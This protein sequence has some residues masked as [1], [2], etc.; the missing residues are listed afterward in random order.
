MVIELRA[1]FDEQA[2]IELANQLQAA[3]AQVVYGVVR[4]KTH[5]KMSMVIRREGRVLRRYVHLGT[6][7]YHARTARAYTDYGLFTCDKAIGEDVH[8]VFQQL[9]AMGRP[10]RLKK[11]LQSPFTLHRD[12][13]RSD[14]ARGGPGVEG[15]ACAR[16]GED[17]RADRSAG[18]PGAV[19]RVA[20]RR[21]D[22]PDRA[23]HVCAAAGRAGRFGQHPRALDRRSL[24][25]ARARVLLR[26]RRRPEGVSVERRLD[27][28]QLLQ[29]RRNRVSDR[30]QAAWRGA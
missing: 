25:R 27:G 24:P 9:T 16:H 14:R 29:P 11:L 12:G 1:R 21:E 17:E 18:H 6:G 3:G 19:S 20:G 7:N 26:K 28:A 23:R 30:R 2:N 4:H 8:K 13:A 15:P 5:A 22:R 10:G